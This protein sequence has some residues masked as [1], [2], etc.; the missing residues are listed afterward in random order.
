MQQPSYLDTLL[1]ALVVQL[2]VLPKDAYPLRDP[3]NLPSAVRRI[4]GMATN[5]GQSWACW[6]DNGGQHWLFVA[7]IPL[8]RGTPLLNL[9]QYDGAGV[10]QARSKWQC[11]ND[12]QWRPCVTENSHTT[13]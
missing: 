11:G 2:N 3:A 1:D 13:P 7:E 10:L 8:T 6:A 12:D 5:V 9:D 4:V